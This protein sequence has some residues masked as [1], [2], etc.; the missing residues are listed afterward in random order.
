MARYPETP[1]VHYAY[2]VFLLQEQPDKAIEEFK[3]ELELQPEHPSSLMQIAFE[4]LK[5][6]DGAAALPWAQTGGR[7][8]A[9]AN[10]R[11]TRRSGRRCS[12]PATSTA[13]SRSWKSASSSRP[14]VPGLHF[15]ARAR[16]SARRPAEDAAREREEFTRLDR[17]ARTQRSGAQSVGGR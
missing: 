13:P 16:L 3:R 9:A 6:T 15:L 14:T 4:Y 7:R 10:S 11:R 5:R 8:R 17:L 1:N 2:G 12:K